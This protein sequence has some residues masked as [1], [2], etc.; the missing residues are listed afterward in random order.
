MSLRISAISDLHGL[1]PA[2]QPCDVLLVAG[3]ICPVDRHSRKRQREFLDGAF[4]KWLDEIPARSVVGI[5][6]NHDFIFTED[7]SAIPDGL[8]WN[9]LKDDGIE[10]DGVRFWGSPWSVEFGN[11]AFMKKDQKLKPIWDKI[12]PETDV[13][14]V[15]GPPFG[16]GDLN[17]Q[18]ERTGSKTLTAKLEELR[19][20]LVVFGHIHEAHGRW[21]IAAQTGPARWLANV[22]HVDLSYQPSKPETRFAFE[23]GV[24][25]I[26]G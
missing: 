7:K 1:L 22:C 8:R 9:Y 16:W 4:R 19:V 2:I 14:L 20:P 17:W 18:G 6:G 23:R 12:P 3:D 21:E 11:W 26:I 15:H 10:I 25:K 24:A 5:A 13:L